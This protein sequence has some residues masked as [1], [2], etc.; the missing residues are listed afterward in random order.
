MQFGVNDIF[1]GSSS[2]F[3]LVPDNILSLLFQSDLVWP[4][5]SLMI[6]INS[7]SRAS[8]RLFLIR[9][10]I[11]KPGLRSSDCLRRRRVCP[12]S[13]ETSH[14]LSAWSR[15]PG[16]KLY[17]FGQSV[18]LFV[19]LSFFIV[20]LFVCMLVFCLFF[21]CFFVCL[22]FCLLFV[23]L[24][25]CFFQFFVLFLFVC[26][27]DCMFFCFFLFLFVCLL[28]PGIPGGDWPYS[29]CGCFCQGSLSGLTHW[30]LQQRRE[31]N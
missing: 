20:S 15:K 23:C 2:G 11:A 12:W 13:A 16:G 30:F 31:I 19:C 5:V 14:C 22:Y 6:S 8:R 9:I 24:I 10:N 21:V 25:V 4:L 7:M 18:C 28:L 27:F 26:L 3:S 17:I 1:W 29:Q